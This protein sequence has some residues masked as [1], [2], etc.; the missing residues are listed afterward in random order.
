MAARCALVRLR[1]WIFCSYQA[2]CRN[3]LSAQRRDMAVIWTGPVVFD[4]YRDRL[5]DTR[6]SGRRDRLARVRSST[7]DKTLRLAGGQRNPR[8]NLGIV[9]FAILFHSW[10]R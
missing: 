1:D 5:L 8:G 10:Q 4:G 3:V 9:A 2:G 6:S 7:D